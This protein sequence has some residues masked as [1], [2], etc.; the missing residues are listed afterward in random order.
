MEISGIDNNLVQHMPRSAQ[1]R[2]I[3]SKDAVAAIIMADMKVWAHH[4]VGGQSVF[5]YKLG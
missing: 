1:D 4:P 5:H 2:L 3:D